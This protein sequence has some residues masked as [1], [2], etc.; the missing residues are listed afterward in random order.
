MKLIFEKGMDLSEPEVIRHFTALSRMNFGVDNDFYPLGSC[1]MK[2]NP[3]IC[4]ETAKLD[5]FAKLHPLQPLS[6]VQGA[7]QL[8]F[9]LQKMLCEITGFKQ[10]SL[11]PAAGAQGELAGIM[12][13]QAYFKKKGEQ[14]T[15]ILVPDSAHGTNPASVSMCGFEAVEVKS[16][17]QGNID[18]NDL[19]QKL[20]HSVA[21]I[22]ITNPNTLGLFEQNI[23]EVCELMHSNGSLVYGDGANLNALLGVCRPVDLGIDLMH[24]NLHK[25]FST[26]HGCG[27]PGAGPIAVI[28]KLVPF[29]PR[30]LIEKKGNVYELD[31]NGKDSIGKVRSFYGNFGVL[32]K[33]YTY[34]RAIGAGGLKEVSEN[35]V[36]NANYLMERLRKHY[37]LQFNRRCMHEFVISDKDMPNGVSTNDIAKR[38]LDYGFHPPTVYFPLIVQGAMMIEPT[39]TESRETLDSFA[40]AM[41]K[42]KE[43]AEKNPELVKSAPHSMPVKRL[44]AVKAAREPI[45][46]WSQ[47]NA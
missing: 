41:I 20:D 43:E 33:A 14:R 16:D 32:V 13:I 10:C 3:K 7:L 39:E 47:K 30:P 8:M 44:D 42:I 6:T 9:E 35:A 45:L 26:P 19:K 37:H 18:L 24:L 31:Y 27:G 17:A 21:A 2:Y 12:M 29:L 5:G 1:T 28:E 34:L 4:E 15:K 36:L 40:D 46:R 23:L 38:L 25:T 22:M 11:Q